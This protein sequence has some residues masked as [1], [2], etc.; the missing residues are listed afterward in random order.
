MLLRKQAIQGR[1]DGLLVAQF[2][3]LHLVGFSLLDIHD[4]NVDHEVVAGPAARA[5]L[6]GEQQCYVLRRRA[7]CRS[8]RRIHPVSSS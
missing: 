5:L 3:A 2:V 6:M 1:F 7:S 4:V 8:R